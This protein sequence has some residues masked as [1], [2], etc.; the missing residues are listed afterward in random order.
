[1]QSTEGKIG[2]YELH[3]FWIYYLT[4]FGLRPSKIAFLALH[5]WHDAKQG[6]WPPGLPPAQR[7]AYDIASIR[8]WLALFL[9]RFLAMSQFKRSALPNAPKVTTGGSLSPRGDWRAPSDANARLW[10]SELL[11]NVPE[12]VRHP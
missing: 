11:A 7:H 3:D 2:P 12:Q 5:A 4:R 1:M 9:E 8:R 6:H 10:V